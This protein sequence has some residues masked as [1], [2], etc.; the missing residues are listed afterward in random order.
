MYV[1]RAR[2]ERKCI[3]DLSHKIGVIVWDDFHCEDGPAISEW[4]RRGR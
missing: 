1:Y 3:V 2:V 4:R